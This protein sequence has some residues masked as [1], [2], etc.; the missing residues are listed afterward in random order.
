MGVCATVGVSKKV[1]S[2][3][4]LRNLKLDDMEAEVNV[5]VYPVRWEHSL[6]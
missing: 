4:S 5:R 2:D 6:A 3:T 1:K